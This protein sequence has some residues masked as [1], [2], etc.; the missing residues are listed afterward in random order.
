VEV[1]RVALR[2]SELDRSIEF[3]ERIAGL[4][5]REREGDTARLG[6]PDGGPVRLELRRARRP[7][8]PARRNAGLFHTAIRYP[9]RGQLGAALRRI[10]TER[11]PLSGASDHLVS[12]ALYLDDPDGLGVELYRDRP[13]DDWPAPQPGERVHMD[14]IPLNLD[15]LLSASD[16]EL[17]DASAGVDIGHVHLKVADVNDAVAFWTGDVGLELMTMFGDDA[18]FLAADGYHHH[19][20][21]NSWFSRGA[22]LEPHDVPGIDEVVLAVD[23][24]EAELTTPDGV[25]V[26]LAPTESA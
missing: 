10:A 21:A 19:I 18:A 23:G 15:D 1:Q 2:V 9:S 20:G 3:Y 25:R 17:P 16:G 13:R 11:H 4:E 8:T 22:P 5:T 26:V 12:E 24:K 6:A 14:T 7:S